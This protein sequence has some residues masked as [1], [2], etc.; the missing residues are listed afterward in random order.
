MKIQQQFDNSG[1]QHCL[2]NLSKVQLVSGYWSSIFL[3]VG[4]TNKSHQQIWHV[5][6]GLEYIMTPSVPWIYC[7]TIVLLVKALVHSIFKGTSDWC[8]QRVFSNVL[9]FFQWRSEYSKSLDSEANNTLLRAVA[10]KFLL[11][12]TC[13]PSTSNVSNASFCRKL[14]SQIRRILKC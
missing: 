9:W 1:L 8:H 2:N 3:L 12:A 14:R 13:R 7:T 6:L 10:K 4:T 11:Q 5:N